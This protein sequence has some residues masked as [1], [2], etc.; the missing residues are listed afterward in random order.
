MRPQPRLPF[1][2]LALEADRSAEQR[3]EPEPKDDVE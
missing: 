3:G 2:Q 1:A